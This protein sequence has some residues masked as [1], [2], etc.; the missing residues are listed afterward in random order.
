MIGAVWL[1]ALA[2]FVIG[3]VLTTAIGFSLGA[4]EANV[5]PAWVFSQVDTTIGTGLVKVGWKALVFIGFL[6]L[7][8]RAPWPHRIGVPVGLA[9]IGAV[10]VG[11]NVAVI[12]ALLA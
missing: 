8:D 9:L 5:L 3:D 11:W 1:L 12:L 2:G 4:A 7:Y 6:W 10:A